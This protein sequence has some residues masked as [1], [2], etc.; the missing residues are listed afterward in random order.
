GPIGSQGI[1]HV[2]V[3]RA[4]PGKGWESQAIFPC[5]WQGCPRSTGDATGA[6]ESMDRPSQSE[7]GNDM[8]ERKLPRIATWL[9]RR[10]GPSEQNQVLV[11]DLAEHYRSGRSRWWYW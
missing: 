5:H 7:R 9:L 1:R 8:K 2:M 4:N 3:R 10:F 11:G 6:H